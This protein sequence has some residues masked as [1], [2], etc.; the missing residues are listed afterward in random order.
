MKRGAERSTEEALN[1]AREC[2]ADSKLKRKDVRA[3]KL[4]DFEGTAKHLNVNIIC[5]NLKK[6]AVRM[7]A[8]YGGWC[9]VKSNIEI[10]SKQ[11][12][13]ACL[14]GIVFISTR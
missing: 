11:L 8:K 6:R 2:Y 10:P 4:I 3:T 7:Q 13:W 12:T 5:M 14:K 9:M 1:L